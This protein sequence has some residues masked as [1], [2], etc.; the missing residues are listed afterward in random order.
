MRLALLASLCSAVLPLAAAAQDTVTVGNQ[1]K[2]AFGTPIKFVNG[3]TAC[4]VTLKD[5]RG[6]TFEELADFELCAQ[7]KAL[8]GKR[9]ALT[10]KASRVQAAS[11]QGDPDCKRS[12]TVVLIVAARP[13][14]LASSAPPPAASSPP[15]PAQRQASFCTPQEAIVFSCRTTGGRMV[16]VCA[17]KD[18]GPARGYLQL[19][20]GKPD[21]SDPLDIVVPDSQL[22]PPRV[23][24]GAAVPFAAG[25]GAWLTFA[26]NQ[27]A[28]TVYTGVGKWGPGG[29]LR[30][31]AGLALD[32]PGKRIGVLRCDNPK[33]T[34]SEIG[35][36]W[37]AAA[38]VKAAGPEFDFPD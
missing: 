28:Y 10:W 32:Q 13:A 30:E 25:G 37:F 12:D 16:S 26:R 4:H 1:K 15:P 11:C 6:A 31:K 20:A 7:E 21:S 9:V 14:P 19:R 5:D 38:G 36:D 17:S 2:R 3:D 33:T 34:R 23:A 35:P 29:E 8:T 24:T 27:V 22:P 18:A